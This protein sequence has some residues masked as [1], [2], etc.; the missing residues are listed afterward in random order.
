MDAI[1]GF[2]RGKLMTSVKEDTYGVSLTKYVT[3]HGEVFLVREPVFSGA[4]TGIG[5]YAVALTMDNVQLLHLNGR[6]PKLRT[7]IQA[8]DV[9]GQKDEFMTESTIAV[10]LEQS[11]GILT[12]VAS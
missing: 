2:A 11:H 1:S 4:T 12:N 6:G 7:N 10:R 3:P 5:G 8:N 9:D